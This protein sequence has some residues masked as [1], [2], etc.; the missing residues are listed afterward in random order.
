MTAAPAPVPVAD[1]MSDALAKR[2]WTCRN[3]LT[4][5]CPCVSPRCRVSDPHWEHGGLD[6]PNHKP[7]RGDV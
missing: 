4:F 1:A 7:V 3:K 6:C 5:S 2:C